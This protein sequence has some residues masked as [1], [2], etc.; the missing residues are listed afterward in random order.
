MKIQLSQEMVYS[1]LPL[2]FRVDKGI[3]AIE[4]EIA[5]EGESVRILRNGFWGFDREFLESGESLTCGRDYFIKDGKPMP[6]VGMTYMQ[7]DVHRKYIYLPNVYL[8][9]RD[10]EEMKKAGINMI[11]T[12]IWTGHRTVMFNDGIASE[13][14]LRAI[15][16]MLLTARKHD[17]PMVFNFFAF[18]P[19]L[20]E[21]VNPYLDPRSVK[22]QK[23]FISSIVSRHVKS[24]GVSWDLINEPSVCNPRQHWRPAPNRDAF[25]LAEWRKW[26]EDRHKRIGNLQERWNC[27]PEQLPSFNSVQLP[28]EED[29]QSRKDFP[30]PLKGLKMHDYVLFTQHIMNKWAGEMADAIH[31]LGSDQLI[32][33]GQ[34]E[35]LAAKRPSPFFYQEAVDYTT[36]HSWWLMDDLY[37]DSIF[38]KTPEKPNLIQETGIMYVQNADGKPRRT[39]VELRNILERKYALAFA[40]D[41]AGAVQWL[42]NINVYMDNVNEV[43]IGAVRADGTQ[44]LE[45]DVS[46]DFGKFVRNTA[47]LF[48]GRRE[49]DT[50]VIYPYANDFSVRDCAPA[51]TKRL[52]RVL[53]YNLGI[54]FKAYGEY[55]LDT[56]KTENLIVLPSPRT[57][58]QEA[59]RQ[60]TDKVKEGS[61]LL[62]TGPF[63]SDEYWNRVDSRSRELKLSTELRNI[64]REECLKING[65]SYRASFGYNKIA[66]IDKEIEPSSTAA[67]LRTI[68]LG[69]GTIIWS[70]LQW[71]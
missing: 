27:T 69:K 1:T 50:A 28:E 7:S 49:A 20:W 70:P 34:D 17:I 30:L 62:I 60:V 56:L 18:A 4:T 14:I 63:S 13:E 2:D 39:E 33:I 51:S 58:T 36:N 52:A 31:S 46:Y 11:R 65:V 3:Y 44:K 59:W 41:N 66:W 38:S 12:G 68:S 71:K 10:F 48:E 19:E 23:R 67:T 32:T 6:V 42:W 55:Q 47:W 21:G 35:A 37:W 26:L 57:L 45:A 53:G 64:N 16:A 8:W 9:D 40:G 5:T 15:D 61:T 24:T 25:E 54:P 43:N 22:A 29:F